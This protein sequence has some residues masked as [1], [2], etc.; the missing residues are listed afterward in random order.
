MNAPRLDGAT[1]APTPIGRPCLYCG[2][3]IADDDRGL[4]TAVVSDLSFPRP[5]G[6]EI[7][8]VHAECEILPLI[9][10]A[11][12]VCACNGYDANR[13]SARELWRRVPW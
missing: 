2:E 5:A 3:P 7:V 9:G 10:H 8:A 11:H 6:G 4:L 12:G 13:D 1:Q